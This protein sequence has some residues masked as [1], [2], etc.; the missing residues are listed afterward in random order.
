MP[1][2]NTSPCL[3]VGAA[4]LNKAAYDNTSTQEVKVPRREHFAPHGTGA[5]R[6]P[7][8]GQSFSDTL[9]L[10]CLAPSTLRC[11]TPVPEG[12]PPAPRLLTILILSEPP[13]VGQIPFKRSQR[14]TLL[15]P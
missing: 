5:A 12:F 6:S 10:P 3:E 9:D 2:T 1:G 4:G 7:V 15:D 13:T 11:Q 14:A 8:L